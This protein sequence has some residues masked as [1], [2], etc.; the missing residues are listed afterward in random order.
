MNDTRES[1]DD[2]ASDSQASML[3][4]SYRFVDNFCKIRTCKKLT[5]L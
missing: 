5:L 3:I 1:I 4:S 2:T